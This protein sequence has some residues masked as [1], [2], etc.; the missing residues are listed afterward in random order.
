MNIAG[1]SL[2][3]GA[4]GLLVD[5][6]TISLV[7]GYAICCIALPTLRM[8]DP[9]NA[10]AVTAPSAVVAIGVVGSVIM[11]F[12]AVLMPPIQAGG[13][14]PVYLIFPAWALIGAGLMRS[15]RAKRS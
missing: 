10:G 3:R 9:S 2:G 12:V 1:L 14:P 7:L 11:A 8:R 5:T 6:I 15:M 4:V 13:F